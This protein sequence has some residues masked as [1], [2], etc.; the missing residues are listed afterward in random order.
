MQTTDNQF[1][2]VENKVFNKEVWIIYLM[3]K[4]MSRKC[5][6]SGSL[7]DDIFNQPL[8]WSKKTHFSCFLKSVDF[9]FVMKGRIV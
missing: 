7:H 4:N 9:Q 6:K 1:G 5:I 2:I 3:N 8:F